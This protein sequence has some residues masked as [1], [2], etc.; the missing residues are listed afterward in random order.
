R[1]WWCH[2]HPEGGAAEMKTVAFFHNKG[3]VGKTS[4]VYHL[5]WMFSELGVR[6]LAVDLAPQANLTS[7]CVP[8]ERLE[9]LW[10]DA[11]EHPDTIHG[12][13]TPVIRGIGDV[14]SPHVESL[15]PNLGLLVGDLA[16]ARFEA[17]L[18]DAWPKCLDRDESAFRTTTAIHR[19]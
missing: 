8:V 4:L 14:R 18:S 5:A 11:A 13:L 1:E 9:E 19:A 16:L 6:T 15:A 2:G 12:A 7:M 10:P 17:R 3:G